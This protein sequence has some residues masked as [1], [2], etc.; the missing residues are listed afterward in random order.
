MNYHE[1]VRKIQDGLNEVTL[2]TPGDWFNVGFLVVSKWQSLDEGNER[3]TTYAYYVAERQEF[4]VS[5]GMAD[6]AKMRIEDA[7]KES[8][9][10][11]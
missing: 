7:F 6:L 9:K 2:E 10:G 8:I 4:D 1:A 11:E 3:S 5:M